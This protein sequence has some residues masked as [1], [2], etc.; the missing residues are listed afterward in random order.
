MKPESYSVPFSF[1]EPKIEYCLG[2]EIQNDRAFFFFSRNDTDPSMLSI[3]MNRL[4]M[5]SV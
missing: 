3:P 1:C 5:I 4:R 2:F